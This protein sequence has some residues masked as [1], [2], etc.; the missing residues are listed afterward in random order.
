V[1]LSLLGVLYSPLALSS[2]GENST[3]VVPSASLSLPEGTRFGFLS[4]HRSL[5]WQ[6]RF[7]YRRLVVAWRRVLQREVRAA[8]LGT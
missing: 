3:T 4:W 5:L 8:A 1:S 7:A 2:K 6:L